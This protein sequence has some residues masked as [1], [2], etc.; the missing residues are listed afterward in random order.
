MTIITHGVA[1]VNV[2]SDG[3]QE[4]V[5]GARLAAGDGGRVRALRTTTVDGVTVAEAAPT[6]GIVLQ[7]GVE[8]GSDGIWVLVNPQ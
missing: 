7:N 5:A 8:A 6:V 1:R 2:S 4:I 3:G